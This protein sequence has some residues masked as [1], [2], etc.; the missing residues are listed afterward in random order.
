MIGASFT[1]IYSQPHFVD[2]SLVNVEECLNHAQTIGRQQDEVL[3]AALNWIE[4]DAT[5]RL[6]HLETLVEQIQLDLC[7][8]QG[9]IKDLGHEETQGN[10]H[11]IRRAIRS[12]HNC[13]R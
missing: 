3:D 9:I 13:C 7:S 1:T 8:L 10:D 11:N 6:D 2:I 4:R 12:T 5:E